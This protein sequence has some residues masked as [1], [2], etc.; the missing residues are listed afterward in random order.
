MP[1][2]NLFKSP[3]VL[4]EGISYEEW[5]RD[6]EI[7]QLLKCATAEEEGPLI[8]RTLSGQAK[9]S[10]NDLTPAQIGANDGLQQII[11]RL[12][13]LYLS[14]ANQRIFK[15][16]DK[17][18]KFKRPNSMS[19]SNFILQFE[20]LHNS[21]KAHKCTYPD[22]V[23]A[24][25]LLK[26]ANLSPHHEE[27][28]KATVETGKWSYQTVVDQLKKIFNEVPAIENTPAVKLES[29][30]HATS[31]SSCPT[32]NC[33]E[34]D[35]REYE[36]YYLEEPDCRIPEVEGKPDISL[37]PDCPSCPTHD[38]HDVYYTP[39]NKSNRYRNQNKPNFNKPFQR[40]PNFQ[41]NS[42]RPPSGYQNITSRSQFD[43]SRSPTPSEFKSL[44]S[45]YNNDPCVTNPKDTKG[46]Y[47]I[48]R[49]CRSIYH[50]VTDCPHVPEGS[51]TYFTAT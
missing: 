21:V 16:L 9:A 5:K 35:S 13:K 38:Q 27:M 6:L 51:N 3:P 4:H 2:N 22:G 50:W 14:D 28:C 12:E 15:I 10:V 44:K 47:T 19:I 24:Y 40:R 7:W 36:D 11:T 20:N 41:P 26:S 1:E 34:K 48:C 17:F 31:Q 8:Y 46:N 45:Q 33:T 30:F 23:L 43:D 49:R 29:T 18:E 32:C 25:R 37:N 42:F 39:F